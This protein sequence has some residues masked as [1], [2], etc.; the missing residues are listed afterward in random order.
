MAS[1]EAYDSNEITLPDHDELNAHDMI[2]MKD[3]EAVAR[4]AEANELQ[5]VSLNEV[6]MRRLIDFLHSLTDRSHLDMRRLI[7]KRVLS[8]ISVFD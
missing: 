6:E 1:L 7:P 4:I 5:P 8:G 3:A 2:L